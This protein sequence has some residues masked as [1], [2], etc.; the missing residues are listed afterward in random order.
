MFAN[1]FIGIIMPMKIRVTHVKAVNGMIMPGGMPPDRHVQRAGTGTMV[2]AAVRVQGPGLN[3][4]AAISM[5]F[6]AALVMTREDWAEI[7]YERALMML[8][9]A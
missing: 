6:S 9:P 8:D 4:R 5:T 1:I 3:A 2:Y 7:A